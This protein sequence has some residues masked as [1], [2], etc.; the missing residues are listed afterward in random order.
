MTSYYYKCFLAYVV[1]QC[2][3][4]WCTGGLISVSFH[5]FQVAF[6]LDFSDDCRHKLSGLRNIS[7]TEGR[8]DSLIEYVFF[9]FQKSLN[10]PFF[11]VHA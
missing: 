7:V 9:G 1:G 6:A 4:K 3:L 2:C 10:N 8:V 5:C 11:K